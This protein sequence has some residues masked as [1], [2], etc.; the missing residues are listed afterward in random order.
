MIFTDTA[1][2]VRTGE[3]KMVAIEKY[4]WIKFET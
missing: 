1:I 2:P 4:G 3:L